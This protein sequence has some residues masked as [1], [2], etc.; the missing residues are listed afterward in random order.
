MPLERYT[1]RELRPEIRQW[2]AARGLGDVEVLALIPND[3]YQQMTP[4]E[5]RQLSNLLE[6]LRDG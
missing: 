4:A 5:Q 1:P 2:L 3:E 6:Q